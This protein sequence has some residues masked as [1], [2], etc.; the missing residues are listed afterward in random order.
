MNCRRWCFGVT[1]VVVAIGI[2]GIPA[3]A[4]QSPPS[5]EVPAVTVPAVTVPVPRGGPEIATPPIST[6]PISTRPVKT[7]PIETPVGT[8]PSVSVPSVKVGSVTV[9][10]VKTVPAS[11]AGEPPAGGGGTAKPSP[12]DPPSAG[13]SS[14]QPAPHAAP[15]LAVRGAATRRS[16]RAAPAATRPAAADVPDRGARSPRRRATSTADHNAPS[17]VDRDTAPAIGLL[18]DRA[19]PT[20]VQVADKVERHD[21]DARPLVDALGP[22]LDVAP[23]LMAL[24]LGGA[25]CVVSR[26][27]RRA[28]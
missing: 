2:G 25:L 7:P 13:G 18:D 3:V 21:A 22:A 10:A 4:Q 28:G 19:G 5:I 27:I 16:E 14:E 8:V 17:R 23:L 6:P 20:P 12:S 1:V 9:P 24:A 26:Q 11:S 15:A